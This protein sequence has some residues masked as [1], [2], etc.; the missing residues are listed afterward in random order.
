MH[1]AESVKKM[2]LTGIFAALVFLMTAYIFHIPIGVSGGYLHF[3]DAFIYLA[4]SMLPTP[5]AMA[6]GAIG[7]G[8]SDALSPGG[9][10]WLIPTVI[11]KSLLC[12][13]FSSREPRILHKRN[14]LALIL[15]CLITL[16]GYYIAGAIITGNWAAGLV[17]IPVSLVQSAGSGAGYLIFGYALDK[18]GFKAKAAL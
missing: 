4:A 5:Y 15:A 13:G 1:K 8:L 17:E 6:A 7:A 16:V 2:C 9:I 18:M 12:L 14:L 10:V 11:I 3:G